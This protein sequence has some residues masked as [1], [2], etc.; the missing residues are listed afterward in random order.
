MD[1]MDSMDSPGSMG[2]NGV[3]LAALIKS[4]VFEPADLSAKY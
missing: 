2:S 1:S 4:K 3:T